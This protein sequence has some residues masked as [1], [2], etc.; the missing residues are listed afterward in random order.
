MEPIYQT[1]VTLAC[2]VGAFIW[3]LNVGFKKGSITSW[4][5]IKVAFGAKD[6]YFD[7]NRCEIRFECTDGITRFSSDAWSNE[8]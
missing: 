2:M 8:K 7:V 5:M 6:L 1:L 3:G 4:T